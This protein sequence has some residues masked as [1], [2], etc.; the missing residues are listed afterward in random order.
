MKLI[1]KLIDFLRSLPSTYDDPERQFVVEV[2]SVD[3][4]ICRPPREPEQRIRMEDLGAVYVE[5]RDC[6]PAWDVWWLLVDKSDVITV[7]YPLNATGSDDVLA[8]LERL[9][10]FQVNGMNSSANARHLCW[11]LAT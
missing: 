7:V 8:R 6:G 3:E 11:Q 4:I 10:G 5:T 1:S 2:T 9:P